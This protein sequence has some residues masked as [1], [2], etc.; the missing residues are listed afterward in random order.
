MEKIS[1]YYIVETTGL[2]ALSVEVEPNILNH[3]H[4]VM[5]MISD[6]TT[7]KVYLSKEEASKLGEVL[8]DIAKAAL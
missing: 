1:N 7:V 6:N 3:T 5:I 8:I 2:G 4:D